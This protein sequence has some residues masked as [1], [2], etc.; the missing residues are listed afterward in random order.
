M[1]GVSQV[2]TLRVL[3]GASKTSHTIFGE[4]LIIV[5]ETYTEYTPPNPLLVIKTPILRA[6]G[7]KVQSVVVSES[8]W[9]LLSA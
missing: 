5:T 3:L 1:W 4:F 2:I 9:R 6:W 8:S 7:F